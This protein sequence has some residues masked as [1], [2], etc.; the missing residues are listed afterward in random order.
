MDDEGNEAQGIDYT[1]FVVPKHLVKE[2]KTTLE[3]HSHAHSTAKITPCDDRLGHF[4]LPSSLHDLGQD[5]SNPREIARELLEQTCYAN[6][7]EIT[8]LRVRDATPSSQSNALELAIKDWLNGPNVL[9]TKD[10]ILTLFTDV[11]K[12]Y[13]IYGPLLLLPPTSFQSHHWQSTLSSESSFELF[14]TISTRLKVT[15]IALNAPIPLNNQDTTSAAAIENIVRSPSNLMPLHGDFGPSCASPDPSTQDFSKAFWTHTKQNGITQVWAPRYTMFS[16]GNITE[17][18]RILNLPAVRSAVQQG[19]E[20]GMGCTAVDLYAGIGY[21][22]FSYAAAGV[23]KVLGWDLNPWSIEGLRR[24]AEKNGWGVAV[25]PPLVETDYGGDEHERVRRAVEKERLV[26]FIESNEKATERV[27]SLRATIPPVRHVNLGLLP[28]SRGSWA[29]AVNALDPMMGGWAHVHENFA[30]A[31]IQDKA[32]EV[33]Q[34]FER[35]VMDRVGSR[36]VTIEHIQ[37]VKSYAPGV[38]HCVVDIY[39]GP[40]SRQGTE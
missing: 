22:A 24:G 31:E 20:T 7:V 8:T 36:K 4:L 17:K 29:I 35:L 25:S 27:E 28:T 15:H 37:R 9:F 39:I 33:R 14:R 23:E 30:V 16:R 18:G 21:F 26:V 2:L 13:S 11:P 34:E 19:R 5:D 40:D 12:T 32:E 6:E 3:K 1:A 38:F 10:E